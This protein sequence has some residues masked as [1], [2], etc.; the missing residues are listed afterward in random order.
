MS[1][2]EKVSAKSGR[3]TKKNL[4]WTDEETALLLQVI[5]D[6]KSS[7]AALGLDW[8]TIKSKYD[9][10]CERLQSLYPKERDEIDL[11]EYPNCSDPPVVTMK[12]IIPKIKLIKGQ[13]RKAV[14]S[15]TRSTVIRMHTGVAPGIF[16]RGGES[17]D[18]GAKIWFSGYCKCQKS[19]KKWL[20]TFRR[21]ASML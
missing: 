21:G 14:D 16:R 18:E 3:S 11:E 1:T 5:I 13:Y 17:S 10:I 9:D 7:K 20:F 2:I 4:P 12:K 15:S 19:P 6:Y 8:E